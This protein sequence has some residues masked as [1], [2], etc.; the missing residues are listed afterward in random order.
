MKYT[1][2]LNKPVGN[3]Q[4]IHCTLF[5]VIGKCLYYWTEDSKQKNAQ[6]MVP[7]RNVRAVVKKEE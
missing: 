5:E 6:G 1:I 2:T 4:M 7:L 3:S